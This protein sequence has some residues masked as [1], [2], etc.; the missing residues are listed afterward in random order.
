MLRALCGI[1]DTEILI[2]MISCGFAPE[3]FQIAASKKHN[4]DQL[5]KIID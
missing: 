3:Q 1:K 4:E 5:M 2:A